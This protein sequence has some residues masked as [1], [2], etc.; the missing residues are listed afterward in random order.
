MTT[1]FLSPVW[2]GEQFFDNN[3]LPLN[4]GKIFTYE[5]GSFSVQQNS[6][7]TIVAD[8]LNSNPM[9]LDSSGRL[10]TDI[11]L[12]STLAYNLVLTLPDG[13]TVLKNVDNVTGVPIIASG[14]PGSS[15][16]WV[17]SASPTYVSGT[18][19]LIPGNEVAHY[20]VGNRVQF[21]NGI[22]TFGYGTVTAVS[23]S[24][25][26]TYVT[27]QCDSIAVGSDISAAY[28][29]ELVVNGKTVDAGAVTYTSGLTY[30]DPGTVGGQ[31]ALAQTAVTAL[32]V[33]VNDT[34][35]VLP[36]SG[37][38]TFV[39]TADAAITN[40]TVGQAF[41]IQFTSALSGACTVNVNAIGALSLKQY[42]YLGAKVDPSLPINT[43][44]DIKYDGT[45]FVISATLPT[46]SKSI[47][48]VYATTS[49]ALGAT[50][51][52]PAN[53]IGVYM[54]AIIY[55]GGNKGARVGIE[56]YDVSNALIATIPVSSTNDNSGG[57]GGSG[58]SDASAAFVP[59]ASNV[60]YFKTVIIAGYAS[61]YLSFVVYARQS[62]S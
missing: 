1:V 34:Y 46:Q 16:V 8:V 35:V 59:M 22:S 50:Y 17:L 27:L 42:D 47:S 3:G 33:R 13:V 6:W 28:W 21:I 19:F 7:T 48:T 23:F 60:S 38:P 41:N 31:I 12:D 9:V 14:G 24:S 36:A 62:Y 10:V 39:V 15:A 5:A 52:V 51:S 11:W 40:Y 32:G 55:G 29:S 44:T 54:Y 4:G 25:P 37:G 26:N 20:T 58:M 57:D 43:V 53:C 56:L 18:E 61:Q 30:S 2:V 49:V 45:D